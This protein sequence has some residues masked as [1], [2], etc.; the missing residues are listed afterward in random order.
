MTVTHIACIFLGA[1]V[2]SIVW[3]Y[4][5]VAVLSERD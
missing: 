5:L 3:I 1:T 4:V 2:S